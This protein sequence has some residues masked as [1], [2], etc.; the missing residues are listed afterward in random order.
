MKAALVPLHFRSGMDEEFRKH[1][2]IV[3]DLLADE[4]E[5]LPPVALGGMIPAA[6]AVFFPQLIGDAFSQLHELQSLPLPVLSL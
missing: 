5:I 2:A 6:D 3:R 4:A 1:L